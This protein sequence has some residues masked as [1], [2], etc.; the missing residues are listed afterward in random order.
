MGMSLLPVAGIAVVENNGVFAKADTTYWGCGLSDCCPERV[1][2]LLVLDHNSNTFRFPSNS[3]GCHL[4]PNSFLTIMSFK[5][6]DDPLTAA[7]APP[8]NES[9][10]EREQRLKFELDAKRRSDAIDDEIDKQRSADKKAPKPIQV[11]LLGENFI[12]V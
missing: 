8:E 9:P 11:L 1:E 5:K 12:N 7:L 10:A 6:Q 2:A 4:F 3:F